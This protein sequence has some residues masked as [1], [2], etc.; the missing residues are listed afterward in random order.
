MRGVGDERSLRAERAIEAGKQPVQCL[1]ERAHL[2]GQARL[3]QRREPARRSLRDR[4]REAPERRESAHHAPADRHCEKRRDD[5]QRHDRPQCH[6]GRELAAR[7][8]RL[9]HL[10]DLVAGERAEHAPVAGRG[11]H[12]VEAELR[13]LRQRLLRLREEALDTVAVPDLDHERVVADDEAA[14][15]AGQRYADQRSRHLP[16]LIVEDLVRLLARA[17]VRGD[18]GGGQ[19]DDERGGEPEEELAADRAA[20]HEAASLRASAQPTPRTLR[21]VSGG[22]LRRSAERWTSTALLPTSSFQP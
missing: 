7:A 9:R 10:D 8:H 16:E 6:A 21:M 18:R 22:S 12:R 15:S 5:E 17:Q 3:V 20:D 11:L 14:R 4:G 13:V 19:R 1:R 2:C